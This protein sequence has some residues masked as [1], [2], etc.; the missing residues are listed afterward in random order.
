MLEAGAIPL[1]IRN[2][3]T[4]HSDFLDSVCT[5]AWFVLIRISLAAQIGEPIPFL[6]FLRG[7]RWRH[8]CERILL[9]IGSATMNSC[10]ACNHMCQRC[11]VLAA[12]GTALVSKHS[13][14]VGTPH[15]R[16]G[17]IDPVSTTDC[18]CC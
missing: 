6:R 11:F 17:G 14:A 10:V 5:Y 9:L 16:S 15:N 12:S 18:Q 8:F 2:E 13:F 1:L 4:P 7:M 3:N